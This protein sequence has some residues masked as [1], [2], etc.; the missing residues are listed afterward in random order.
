V[1]LPAQ[2]GK[3]GPEVVV[4]QV[5]DTPINTTDQSIDRVLQVGLPLL[6]AFVDGGTLDATLAR[7]AREQAGKLLVVKLNARDNPAST[8]RFEVS[9]TPAVVTVRNGETLSRAAP[10]APADVQQHADFLLGRGPRPAQPKAARTGAGQ[11]QPPAGTP[12]VVTDATFE[13]QVMRSTL[14]VLIDFW[15]PW[16][17]PCRMIA[18]MVDRLAQEL[19]SRLRVVKVNVDENPMVQARF[20]IQSIPTMM[21]VKGG[22]VVDRWA[23]ALPEPALRSRVLQNLG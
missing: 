2:A 4:A 17:G 7:L 9:A 12:L 20:G 15:A 11:A 13:Q 8:R 5:F 18:P 10:A 22:Q 3:A 16:C 19:G 23:G 6:L 21:L 1:A 14:P